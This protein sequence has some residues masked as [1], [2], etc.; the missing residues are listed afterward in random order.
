MRR[1]PH[2]FAKPS[3]LLPLAL[4][5]LAAWA[6]HAHAATTLTTV[7]IA[8]G[9]SRPVFVGSPPG[10]PRIFIVE[11]RGSDQRGRIKIYKNGAILPTPFLTT[12]P[13]ATGNEQGLLGLAF[14]P[15]YATSGNFYI[16]YTDAIGRTRIV[17]HTASTA[18]PDSANPVGELLL[19]ISQPFPNHNGGYL[20]FGPDGYLYI[21]TGDGGSQDDPGNRAQHPDSL[22][23]K[24][25]RI[26][27]SD[28]GP[29]KIPPD[30]PFVGI[31]GADEIWSLGLRNPF[32][33]SFDRLTGDFIIGDV[34][35]FVIEEIDFAPAPNRGRGWNYGWP[36][37]E[38]GNDYLLGRPTPLCTTC[39][40]T[41]CFTFPAHQYDHSLGRC[42][43]TGG[44][45][46]R[47]CAIPDLR[48]TYFFADH[49]GNQIYS[50]RFVGG[51]LTGVIPRTVELD[52]PGTIAIN[53]ISSFGEDAQG[54]LYIC[55]LGGEVFKVI[56]AVPVVEADQPVLQVA[57]A[58]GDSLGSTGYGNALTPGLVPF[59]DAG[60]RIRGVG[61]LRNA[62]PR[63]CVTVAG[64]CL[65]AP[66]RIGTWDLDYEACVDPAQAL[67]TRTL[68][69]TNRAA[70]AQELDFRDVIAPY[71][72][73]DDDV[74]ATYVPAGG[75]TSALLVLHD[76]TSPA[77]YLA[78]RGI[79]P[80]GAVTYSSDVDLAAALEPRIAGDQALTGSMEAGPGPLALALGFNFGSVPVNES[81]TLIVETRLSTSPPLDTGPGGPVAG[82]RVLRL[83]GAMP[84]RSSLRFAV[85]LP[86]A[87]SVKL[88][89]Y[90]T[91]GRHVRR[92][93]D[94]P[95]PA[96]LHTLVWDGRDDGGADTGPGLYYVHAI[97]PAGDDALKAI[98]VP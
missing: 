88:S 33:C 60:S 90:D 97:T 9:L 8:S 5:G 58:L 6:A 73:G 10:D 3:A 69:F 31:S 26:D 38:G 41:A 91:R 37:Y 84:F 12:A 27:V 83:L 67:L 13:L 17:R 57:T 81:R 64:D 42:S 62:V 34:G 55:D 72:E 77:R 16:N 24:V 66:L 98:R 89:V 19:S 82:G 86:Q 2:P 22:L 25:L 15:D 23:G 48:G 93:V 1:F 53:S 92:L 14:A 68:T 44:Y 52:P 71:L 76:A 36:C 46:Y 63:G 59:A 39:S 7:R 74:G 94:G 30:N 4:V 18:N 56:P 70:S 28:P 54:E 49:C 75:D 80:G 87:G 51:A 85:D 61:Y 78:Q 43:V 47:G 40:N 79:V 29:Y 11:Q 96:G 45:V 21:P 50:G 65:T 35:Q 95:M 20:G 32:R